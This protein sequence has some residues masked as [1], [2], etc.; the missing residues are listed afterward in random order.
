MI[1]VIRGR[2]PGLRSRT[3]VRVDDDSGPTEKYRWDLCISTVVVY[4]SGPL[5]RGRENKRYFPSSIFVM[6]CAPC[7]VH[8]IRMPCSAH[9]GT[10]SQT[11]QCIRSLNKEDSEMN[12]GMTVAFSHSSSYSS[13]TGTI[14]IC[15]ILS[16]V[17]FSQRIQS[18]LMPKRLVLSEFKHG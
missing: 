1:R 2:V 10:G 14:T 6:V 15:P 8:W 17:T 9:V 3:K 12:L 16:L 13:S 7:G 18:L 11:C 4:P 5:K